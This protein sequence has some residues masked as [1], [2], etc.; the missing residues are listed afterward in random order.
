MLDKKDAQWW[1]LEAEKHPEQA[2]DL[3][4]MLADRL[5]FLDKQYETLSGEVITLK[6]K[7]RGDG[8]SADVTALQQRVRELESALKQGSALRQLVVYAADRIEV[9]A[10]LEN[11]VK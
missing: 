9:K 8:D 4:R 10:T 6:R 5:S 3:I 11:V 1:V 7:S 2:I